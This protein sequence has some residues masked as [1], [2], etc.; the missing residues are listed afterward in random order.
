MQ[1][2]VL[3]QAGNQIKQVTSDIAISAGRAGG[4]TAV[5]LIGGKLVGISFPALTLEQIGLGIAVLAFL[6]DQWQQ[7]SQASAS[8]LDSV[9]AEINK[10]QD[11]VEAHQAQFAHPGIER[12]FRD[13]QTRL[14]SAQAQIAALRS[15]L[16]MAEKINAI[17]S[18]IAQI[19]SPVEGGILETENQKG[20]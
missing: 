9:L 8:K 12:E 3:S 10:L 1:K 7:R 11:L 17:E 16:R 2:T 18:A 15:Q 13:A 14:A 20:F 19:V 6:L 4:I 5:L